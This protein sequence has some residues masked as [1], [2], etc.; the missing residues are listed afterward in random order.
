MRV[1]VGTFDPSW[2]VNELEGVVLSH[3]EILDRFHTLLFTY[4]MSFPR[5]SKIHV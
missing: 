3:W 1:K 4:Y 5:A 2:Q